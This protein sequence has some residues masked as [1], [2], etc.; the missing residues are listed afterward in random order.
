MDE[1]KIKERKSYKMF[2]RFASLGATN[3]VLQ[4]LHDELN[5]R[6]AYGSLKSSEY[7]HES[8][9]LFINSQLSK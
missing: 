8:L 4:A 9:M 3:E 1:K 2:E 6:S 5:S 7:A